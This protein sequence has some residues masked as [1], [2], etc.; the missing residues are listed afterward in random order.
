MAQPV[1]NSSTSTYCSTSAALGTYIILKKI[2]ECAQEPKCRL[3]SKV[4]KKTYDSS[5]ELKR[6][7]LKPLDENNPAHEKGT[8]ASRVMAP[9]RNGQTLDL[10]N[11]N[12]IEVA[13]PR[14]IVALRALDLYNFNP[15]YR[16]AMP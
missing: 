6:V 8:V 12:L 11:Y 7:R 9:L 13:I 15:N 2:L 4:W 14:E 3:V 10:R 5:I 16:R 1:N